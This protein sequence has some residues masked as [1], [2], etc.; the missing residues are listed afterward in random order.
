[1]VNP[2]NALRMGRSAAGLV[3]DELTEDFHPSHR[4]MLEIEC[5][6]HGPKSIV[7][8]FSKVS[9]AGMKVGRRDI[10]HGN[11]SIKKHAPGI[12]E[13]SD[14]TLERGM[15]Q[16]VQLLQW[17]SAVMRGEDDRRSG[18]IIALSADGWPSRLF[19]FTEAYPTEW[20]GI[21]LDSTN[22]NLIIEG[23]TLAMGSVQ[24]W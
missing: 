4:F 19:T 8:G 23:M 12:V 10:T 21:N 9:G 13:Y 1:M 24:W 16:D 7:G 6:L 11:D 3:G 17:I 2:M 20:K 22:S 14:L 15:T 18:A 5:I